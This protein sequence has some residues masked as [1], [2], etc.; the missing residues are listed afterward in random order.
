MITLFSLIFASLLFFF[1]PPLV[2]TE[3]LHANAITLV[4]GSIVFAAWIAMQC[5]ALRSFASFER[6]L[7]P[8]I[9]TMSR[10]D[11][12][13]KM[14]TLILCL[15]VF[16]SYLASACLSRLPNL[17]YQ[18]ILYVA[19]FILFAASLDLCHAMWSR[20]GHLLTPSF[21]ITRLSQRAFHAI[22][23][24]DHA[25]FLSSLDLLS[26]VGVQ[27]VEQGKLALS[28][29]VLQAFPSLVQAFLQ[30][31]KSISH[32]SGKL[33][34]EK[35]GLGDIESFAL[36]YLLQR[37]EFIYD[38]AI[39]DRQEAV[40]RQLI[41]TLGLLIVY[42]A[43]HDLTLVAFPTRVLTQCGLKAQHHLFDDVATLTTSTLLEIAKTIVTEI[44]VT[45]GNLQDPFRSLLRGVA[46]LVKGTLQK[47]Q[48]SHITGII[49][50]LRDLRTLLETERL[51]HH[52]D[53]PVLIREIDSLLEEISLL[54]QVMQTLPEISETAP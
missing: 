26:E 53:Q 45:Y 22:Q 37:L 5:T 39:R 7:I 31:E 19:W 16:F 3:A 4:G 40:C 28:I 29:Q 44:D 18:D 15:F 20:F 14:G 13:I 2:D 33:K 10:R 52:P 24:D 48:S 1:H 8:D 46:A 49:Q 34:E 47:Q 51:A 6:K 32:L 36:S 30:S 41:T 42:C 23:Q 27:A 11:P 25:D 12:L 9:M 21:L 50:P 35:E 17:F 38:K 43:K 54:G